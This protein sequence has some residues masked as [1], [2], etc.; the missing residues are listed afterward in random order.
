MPDV[1]QRS[2]QLAL[3]LQDGADRLITARQRTSFL[4]SACMSSSQG[5]TANSPQSLSALMEGRADSV[6]STIATLIS[7]G[8]LAFA[9]FHQIHLL[10]K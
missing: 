1:P 7:V 5:S 2:V 9:P 6:K 4:F 10:E 8:P 3:S